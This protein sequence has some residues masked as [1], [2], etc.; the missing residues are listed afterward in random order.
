MRIGEPPASGLSALSSDHSARKTLSRP[1]NHLECPLFPRYLFVQLGLGSES[2]SWGSICS[3]KGVSW[4]VSV[5][6]GEVFDVAADIRGGVELSAEN[7]RQLWVPPGFAH[8]FLMLS[9]SADPPIKPWLLS[10]GAR[11]EIH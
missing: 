1:D 6:Q 9:A 3:T 4:L 2:K 10:P 5:V 8:G 7:F 11:A